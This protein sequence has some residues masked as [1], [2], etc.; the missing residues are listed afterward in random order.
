MKIYVCHSS[1]FDYEN[2][3]YLPL[4]ESQLSKKHKL[5]YPHD[6][7]NTIDIIKHSDLIIPEASYPST[8]MGIEIGRAEMF[9]KKIIFLVKKGLKP[10]SLLRFVSENIIEY[11]SKRDLIE[12][13]E[14]YLENKK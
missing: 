5:F 10:S 13:L 11:E 1:S 7:I 3:L 9:N 2:E 4:K 14:E 12:K 8:G 6:E